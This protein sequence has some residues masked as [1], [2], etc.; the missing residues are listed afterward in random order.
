MGGLLMVGYHKSSAPHTP[1]PAS[2][3]Q[4]AH[5]SQDAS[6]ECKQPKARNTRV[7]SVSS[8]T[9]AHPLTAGRMVWAANDLWYSTMRRPPIPSDPQRQTKRNE[10]RQTKRSEERLQNQ[11]QSG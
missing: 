11:Q 6:Q 4:A 2:N 9:L 3:L 10:P 1:S 8:I 5:P 7:S